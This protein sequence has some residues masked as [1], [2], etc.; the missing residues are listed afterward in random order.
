VTR[1]LRFGVVGVIG[2]LVDAG[3]LML[4]TGPL[5]L[6]AYLARVPSF[7]MGATSTWLCNRY[8]TFADRRG[9]NRLREW[10]RYMAAMLVGGLVNYGT[11]ALAV[12]TVDAVRAMPVIGVALGSVAGMFVNYA[13][14]SR[15]IFGGDRQCPDSSGRRARPGTSSGTKN[16]RS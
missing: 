4:L 6:N 8:W 5:V 16:E 9:R 1:L 15:L 7:L 11:F 14:S 12:A 3:V 2:F 10:S 13:S